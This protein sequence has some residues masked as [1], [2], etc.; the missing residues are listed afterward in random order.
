MA[1]QRS[2]SMIGNFRGRIDNVILTEWRGISVLKKEASKLKKK[3]LSD[4]QITNTNVF[5]TVSN[6]LRSAKRAFRIGYQVPR[7][8]G[9]TPWNA[10]VSDHLKNAI[11]IH[12]GQAVFDLSKVQLSKPIHK[13]QQVWNP[14]ISAESG[15]KVTLRWELTP[16]PEKCT[17]MDDKVILACYDG[18]TGRFSTYYTG[19]SRSALSYTVDFLD[20]HAGH[21][22]Y[23]YVFMVS[24]NGKLVS[25]TEYLGMVTVRP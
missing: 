15:Y 3:K 2:P 25:E 19:V 9:F 17:R 14:V 10:I 12:K 4:E 6:F 16:E 13:T 24:D 11:T 1:T 22:M 23:W 20:W 5:G 8:A 21:D 18:N 7:K